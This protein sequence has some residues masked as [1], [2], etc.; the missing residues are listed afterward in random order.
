MV[1]F[2]V[3][4]LTSPITA[5]AAGPAL[6]NLGTAGNFA[7]LSKAGIT[8][9][10]SSIITGNIG[11][12]PISGSAIGVTCPEVTGI[13]YSRDAAGPLPCRVINSSLLN[14]AV[15]NMGT[16]YTNAAGRAPGVGPNLN[17]GSGTLS[18]LILAPG[19]YTWNTPGNVT[20][21]GDITLIGTATDVW[22]FQIS[23]TLNISSG[24]KIILGGSAQASNIFWQV[25][26]A[27]TLGT[28]S[29][30]NG[31]ILDQTMIAL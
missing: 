29:T 7:I 30:F 13:I 18:G 3:F 10:P 21:T 12:Y 2:T 4:A 23:G 20:V 16:A 25:A 6:V 17:L 26:G 27:T 14:T 5:L 9:I 8:D 19:T 28:Y 11:T 15:N 24:K 22:I 31:N 1:I